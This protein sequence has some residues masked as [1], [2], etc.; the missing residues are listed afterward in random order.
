MTVRGTP[1]YVISRGRVLAE[2]GA[3]VGETGRGVR[4]KSAP[5]RPVQL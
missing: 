2:G 5:F 3:Y 4:R 1:R